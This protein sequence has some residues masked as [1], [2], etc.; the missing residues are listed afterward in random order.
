[1][2]KARIQRSAHGH[3]VVYGATGS[4]KARRVRSIEAVAW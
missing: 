2:K 3:E 4:G 1:M